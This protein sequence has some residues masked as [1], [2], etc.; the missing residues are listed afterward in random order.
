MIFFGV[1]IEDSEQ[2]NDINYHENNS[3]ADDLMK[4]HLF[5]YWALCPE[6][7]RWIKRVYF[8]SLLQ[9]VSDV[10]D[11]VIPPDFHQ[12]FNRV[13]EVVINYDITDEQID[14]LKHFKSL[15]SI[16][17]R[18]E[19]DLTWDRSGRDVDWNDLL[20]KLAEA[21]P[22]VW[23]LELIDFRDEDFERFKSVYKFKKLRRLLTDCYYNSDFI[24]ELF[25]FF[26]VFEVSFYENGIDLK[27]I[28]RSKNS[29][30][31]LWRGPA[32]S[33]DLHMEFEDMDALYEEIYRSFAD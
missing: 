9:C 33:Y 24:S 22:A 19:R 18:D 23:S 4:L 7:M 16:M 21:L 26:D 14:T 30:L 2:L 6:E 13:E 11:E 15:N 28:R 10:L 25:E 5:N 17:I 20:E 29:N 1:R 12:M 32:N 8:S 3:D 31:E 27:V